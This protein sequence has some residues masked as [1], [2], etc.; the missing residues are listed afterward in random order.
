MG[1]VVMKFGGSSVA[2]PELIKNVA[3]KVIAKKK[4][5]NDVVV[6]VS[7]MGDTTDNLISLAKQI[8]AQPPEREMDML[9][10]TGEQITIALLSMA[11]NSMHSPAISLT[12]A[13]VGIITDSV[14]TKAKIS[15]IQGDRILRELSQGKIVVVAGFQGINMEDDITTLG[16]GGSDTTAVALAAALKADVCEIYT[17]V[18]GVYTADPRIVPQARKMNVISYDEM[19]ELAA[20]GAKVLQSRSVE[21]A[22]NYDVPLLVLSTFEN[23]PPD[24][25]VDDYFKK[26]EMPGTLVIG[27]EVIMER[28]DKMEKLIITG[29]AV[30]KTEAR[31]GL[32]G[33]PDRPGIAAQIFQKIAE[34]NVNVDMIVQSSAPGGGKNHIS[35]TINEN[36]VNKVKEAI[37]ELPDDIKPERVIVDE[38]IAKVSIVGA[39]MKSYPGVAAKMFLALAEEGINIEMISTSE[40]KI[41][42][43]IR[44]EDADKAVKKI[45]SAFNLEEA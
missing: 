25:K 1:L 30:L 37:S 12:G 27:Q 33:V 41:S 22:K 23:I 17:D 7:A 44:R 4:A 13:Q 2:T 29:V 14:H 8:T 43:I 24:I 42:C 9:L 3:N 19:L 26:E 10:S 31:V 20:L 28:I 39:G 36:D 15:S 5:G 32:I 21:F 18:N 35:F 6:V 11:L 16:R 40:I 45:H 34:K 38:D